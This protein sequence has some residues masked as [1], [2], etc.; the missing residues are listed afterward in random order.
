M[1]STAGHQDYDAN[2]L[3]SAPVATKA[4]LQDGYDPVLLAEK[5]TP[6]PSRRDLEAGVP[7]GE[8]RDTAITPT[9]QPFY[10]TKKGII[11]IFVAVIVIIAVVVG[12]AVGG[13]SHKK[14]T[15]S[16]SDSQSGGPPPSSTSSDTT[17]NSSGENNTQ[18]VVGGAPS[19][20]PAAPDP[21]STVGPPS[22]TS[23]SG[24][25]GIPSSI[26]GANDIGFFP[27]SG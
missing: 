18:Q 22:T 1:A 4:Q 12:G 27:G 10:R 13:S 25:L 17:T 6:L 26:S 3:A 19:S 24:L 16:A 2:L 20:R 21:N 14:K 11:I 8:T 23:S 15:T 7:A 5:Q 9:K